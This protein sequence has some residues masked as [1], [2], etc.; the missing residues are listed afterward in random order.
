M[1][2]EGLCPRLLFIAMKKDSLQGHHG[3]GRGDWS[4]CC[5]ASSVTLELHLLLHP[6]QSPPFS[7]HVHWAGMGFRGGG[8]QV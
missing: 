3:A 7:I 6:L 5:L 1:R 8:D 2:E 4:R